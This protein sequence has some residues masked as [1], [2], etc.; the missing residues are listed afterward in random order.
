MRMRERIA[1][2]RR[3]VHERVAVLSDEPLHFSLH[4]LSP[5][6]LPFAL[7]PVKA[8]LPGRGHQQEVFLRGVQPAQ[9]VEDD[10]EFV[11]PASIPVY[12][13]RRHAVRQLRAG[14]LV[15]LLAPHCRREA[16][17]LNACGPGPAMR[18][19]ACAA[20]TRGERK[21]GQDAT[22]AGTPVTRRTGPGWKA[23]HA[24]I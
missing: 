20:M 1:W 22:T 11:S 16:P 2:R 10:G 18:C 4:I 12:G 15:E 13:Q 7:Q 3:Q 21:G 8:H 6:P 17:R 19:D 23:G 5:I 14:H 24:S 9:L